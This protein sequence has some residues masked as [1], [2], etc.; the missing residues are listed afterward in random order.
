MRKP[1]QL[2]GL[3]SFFLAVAISLTL[4]Q[5]STTTTPPP[6]APA[7]SQGGSTGNASQDRA[8]A[9]GEDENPLN[10]TDEQRQKL[11]PI[12]ADERSEER[13]VGKEC[14]SRGSRYS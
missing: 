6:Q 3:A 7:Q 12:I 2:A 4:A 8:Q 13:R 11:R 9:Q 10:L 1:Y 14:R 5:T